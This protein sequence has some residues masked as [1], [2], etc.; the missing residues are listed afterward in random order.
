MALSKVLGFLCHHGSF[1]LTEFPERTG[2]EPS[3]P[4]ASGIRGFDLDMLSFS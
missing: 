1:W 2:V 3:S 4:E